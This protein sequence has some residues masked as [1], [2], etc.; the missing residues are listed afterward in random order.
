MELELTTEQIAKSVLAA[1]DSV[2]LITELKAKTSLTEEETAA[3]ARNVEHIKIMLGKDWFS[4]ALTAEQK[5][6]LEAI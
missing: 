4:S 2:I 1:Y 3:L 5:T 6:E